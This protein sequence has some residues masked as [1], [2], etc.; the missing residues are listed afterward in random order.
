M[1]HLVTIE[2]DLT[3]AE[4]LILYKLAN[5]HGI[6]VNAYIEKIAPEAINKLIGAVK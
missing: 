1:S 2:L 3:E 5:K 4:W 6:T